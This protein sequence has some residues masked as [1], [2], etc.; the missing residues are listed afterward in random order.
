MGLT[1][2]QFLMLCTL[3]FVGAVMLF[4]LYRAGRDEEKQKRER[5]K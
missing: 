1:F 3:A 4:M 2:D 5:D